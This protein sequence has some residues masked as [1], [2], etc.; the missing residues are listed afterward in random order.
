MCV[1]SKISFDIN[2]ILHISDKIVY[3]NMVLC[4]YFWIIDNGI[5]IH[6]VQVCSEVFR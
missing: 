1:C 4:Y 5:H 3:T 2:N 6:N